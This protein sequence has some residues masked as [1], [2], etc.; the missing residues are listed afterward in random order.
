MIFDVSHRAGE[1]EG[2]LPNAPSLLYGRGDALAASWVAKFP[3]VM[4][5]MMK[6]RE[7]DVAITSREFAASED[8]DY[9]Q[10]VWAAPTTQLL[11]CLLY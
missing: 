1:N 7:P 6:K 11:K 5:K 10:I 2:A 3:S 4:A 9:V 8:A